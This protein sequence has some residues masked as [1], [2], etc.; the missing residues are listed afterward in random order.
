MIDGDVATLADIFEGYGAPD[1]RGTAGY[2]SGLG[3]EEIVWHLDDGMLS[4]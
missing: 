4:S 2:G 1:S 3:E